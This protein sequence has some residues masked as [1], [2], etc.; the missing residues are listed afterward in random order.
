[1][2]DEVDVNK[3]DATDVNYRSRLVGHEFNVGRD[4][5][6]YASNS[7]LEALRLIVSYAATRPMTGER[8]MMMINDVRRAYAKTQR[9]VYIE[10][11]NEDP[12]HGKG[13]LGKLKLLC[14]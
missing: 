8:R 7:P 5:A 2:L 1:M 12:N 10:L 4:D 9:D 3:E 6:L 13:M 14:V 11:P